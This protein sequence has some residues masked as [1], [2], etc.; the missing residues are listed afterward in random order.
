MRSRFVGCLNGELG[1]SL[2]LNGRDSQARGG[3][4]SHKFTF[5]VRREGWGGGD[6]TLH[7]RARTLS[8]LPV[9]AATG[10]ASE[11]AVRSIAIV[12]YEL[13]HKD[14]AANLSKQQTSKY[15]PPP[16]LF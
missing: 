9:D 13:S 10:T 4:E 11:D 1:I 12:C 2:G 7:P 5:L 16:F 8:P 6:A 14:S 3:D 15:G